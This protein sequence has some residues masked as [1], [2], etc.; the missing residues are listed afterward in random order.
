[1]SRSRGKANSKECREMVCSP[2]VGCESLCSPTLRGDTQTQRWQVL[3]AYGVCFKV[4]STLNA[5]YRLDGYF[6]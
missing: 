6:I 3:A 5:P 1:M 2:R 4:A